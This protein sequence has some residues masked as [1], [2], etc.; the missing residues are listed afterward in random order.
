MRKAFL[1]YFVGMWKIQVSA[2]MSPNFAFM[3]QMHVFY[4][5]WGWGGGIL[6]A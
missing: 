3:L 1:K 6:E 2:R 4:E 5:N